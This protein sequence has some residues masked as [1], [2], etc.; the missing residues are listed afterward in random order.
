ML[1]V[2]ADRG[3]AE[4]LRSWPQ[5]AADCAAGDEVLILSRPVHTRHVI[6]AVRVMCF[7]QAH[8]FPN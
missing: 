7:E 4:H 1:V 2:R 8:S 6:A 5:I 3:L